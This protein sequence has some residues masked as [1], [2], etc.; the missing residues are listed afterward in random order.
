V[1]VT[2]DIYIFAIPAAQPVPREFIELEI[3]GPV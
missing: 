3:G 2:Q 1:H